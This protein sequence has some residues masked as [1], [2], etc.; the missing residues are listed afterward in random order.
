MSIWLL[1]SSGGI[2][3]LRDREAEQTARKLAQDIQRA[4]LGIYPYRKPQRGKVGYWWR[5][6]WRL[7]MRSP[8][9]YDLRKMGRAIERARAEGRL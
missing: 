7:R 8:M 2:Q 6:Q 1:R 3:A 9:A 4:R 5:R